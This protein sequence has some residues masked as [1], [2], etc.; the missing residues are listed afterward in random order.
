MPRKL[1]YDI[2]LRPIHYACVSGGKDS[3]YMLGVILNNLNKYPLEMV[4]NFDIDIEWTW[5]K[6]SVNYI[7]QMCTKANINFWRIKPRKTWDQMYEKYRMPTRLCRWC[8][9]M[10][11]LDAEKQL[12]EWIRSQNCRPIAYIGFCA[13]EK[14]R[15]KYQ[16]GNWEKGIFCYPL[17]EE[18]ILESTVLEWA[19]TVPLFNN[20]YKYF[21]RQGCMM[22]P[23]L[24][25]K[26][27]A[28]MYKYE[29]EHFEK[30]FKC[31]E[32]WETE[33]NKPYYGT[34][35]GKD[36][37]RVVIDKWVKILTEEEKEKADK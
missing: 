6:Q 24:T 29:R 31:I 16:L 28:Y 22:C 9:S 26:E 18:G 15:F 33:F 30:Y 35:Y 34:M 2:S 17:A 4:V 5:S 19:R 25:R 11:K 21:D 1:H 32:E 20:W 13:D 8:N 23:M 36:V 12:I 7:E 10:Y 14:R 3:L 27:V 37:K